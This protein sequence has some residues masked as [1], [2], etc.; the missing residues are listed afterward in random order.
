MLV[1]QS[2]ICYLDV[3]AD[4]SLFHTHC[5]QH[6][7]RAGDEFTNSCSQRNGDNACTVETL[8]L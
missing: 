8:L 7:P 4:I 5:S 6:R 2:K 1:S 3:T